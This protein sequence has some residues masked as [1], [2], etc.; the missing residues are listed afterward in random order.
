MLN[1]MSVLVLD[2]N[3]D[4][5]CAARLA[6]APHT[7]H[8]ETAQSLEMIE[9]KLASVNFD[10]VLLDMNFVAGARSGKEGLDTLARI[11]A[12]DSAMSVVLMTAYGGV[13]LA[14]EA[15]KQGAADFILKPWR[16]EK[17]IEAV[18]AAAEHTRRQRGGASLDL[19]ALERR[20]IERALAQFDRN[21]SAAAAALGLS[22][23]ALYRRMAK[24]GL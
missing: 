21:I 10:V 8:I 24:Y 12:C 5:L 1:D 3:A 4:I 23:T 15:L 13:S 6:L 19:D 17:L 20:T 16:N 2:D 22:R 14:V 11:L 18:N 9:E 7:A